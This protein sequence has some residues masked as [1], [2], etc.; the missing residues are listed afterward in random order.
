MKKNLRRTGFTLIELLISIILM[1]I[2]LSAITLIFMRTTETV[3]IAQARMSVYTNA[4]YALDIME[5]DLLGTVSFNGGQRFCMENGKTNGP[6]AMPTYGVTGNHFATAADRFVFRAT[7]TVANTVQTAEIT[8]ELIPGNMALGPSGAIVAGDPQRGAT[9]RNAPYRPLFTLIRR[10]RVANPTNPSVYD[11]IPVDSFG[12]PAND[13]ELCY[14]VTSF[15]LEYYANNMTFSQLE[16]SY[17]TQAA[18]GGGAYDPLGNGAGG[19]DGFGGGT[20]LRV[21]YVRVT[22]TIVDDIGERQERTI[23]KAMWIPMG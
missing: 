20:A 4:R 6:G 11:Q 2:L 16:P 12:N 9:M 14:Y 3:A 17:F 7:T 18:A 1:L 19:N 10:A 21:P 23:S 5:N 13:T 15:N 8:Y 22:M